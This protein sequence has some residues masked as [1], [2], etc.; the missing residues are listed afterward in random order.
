MYSV[1]IWWFFSLNI[2][3]YVIECRLVVL[4]GSR[5]NDEFSK[6]SL[7]RFVTCNIKIY[8]YI[9]TTKCRWTLD[10]VVSFFLFKQ[11]VFMLTRK[12]NLFRNCI[13]S[14]KTDASANTS[15]WRSVAN[16]QTILRTPEIAPLML[17][18]DVNSDLK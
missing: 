16:L 3:H 12:L 10:T 9:L 7:I 17:G 18:V 5:K 4:H 15:R 14:I 13:P 1:E 8:F 6:K 2:M 11:R